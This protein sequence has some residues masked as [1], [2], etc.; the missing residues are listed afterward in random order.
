MV[1]V[2]TYQTFDEREKPTLHFYLYTSDYQYDFTNMV[3]SHNWDGDIN[4]ACESFSIGVHNKQ[5]N[6]ARRK[7]PFE[8]GLMIKV[9]LE[10]PAQKN[11]PKPT[12]LFRGIIAKRS[13]SGDGSE[14][15]KVNDYNWYF[16][17]NQV[18]IDFKNKTADQIISILCKKAGVGVS[19]MDKTG[20]VFPEL[21]F[22]R[23]TIW[24]II[25]A[26]LTETYLR[27]KKR[28]NI[29]SEYGKLS[30]R[31][32]TMSPNRM[33]IERGYNLLGIDR[34]ISIEDVRT[35]VIMTGGENNDNP[36]QIKVDAAAKKKYGTLT[37]TEHEQ[38]LT[39]P[40]AL[41]TLAQSLLDELKKPKDHLSV[42]ALADYHI[43]AGTLIEVYDEFT[44]ANDYYF[45]TAHSHSGQ[46][47]YGT[48]SLE[49]SKSYNPEFVRY[50]KPEEP[51]GEAV[52]ISFDSKLS[53][54]AYTSGFVATAYDPKLGGIN[55]SGDYS[56]TASGTK[57]AYSRTIA[58][59]PKVIPY[60]SIVH[61]VVPDMPEH[62][63]LYLAEDTG[64]AIDG[65]RIDMLIRGKKATANFGRRN[66]QVAILQKGTGK[67]DAKAK[68]A[69]WR[70]IESSWKKKLSAAASPKSSGGSADLGNVSDK[71]KK[72]VNL[73]RSYKGELTYLWSSMNVP[74][75][76]ADCS[77]FT[78]Y[79]LKNAAGYNLGRGTSSQ[80]TK[81]KKIAK[82]S[83]QPGDMVFFKNTYR[84]GVSHVGIVTTP[85]MCVSVHDGGCTEHSYTSGYW[86]GKFMQINRVFD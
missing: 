19:Y 62:N 36:G 49:L 72:V 75:G 61:I 48:M 81:G 60:G 44:G 64:G 38:D 10:Y 22:I 13:L 27:T 24:E 33:V 52:K 16:Q 74:G 70:S 79:I 17:R 37:L 80:V 84:T 4:L 59:D 8:E 83:A 20:Y 25:Q 56:M 55:G 85:G 12:E 11:A 30:L 76:T 63:G 45:V 46:S 53:D 68:A 86:G 51:K 82:S 43:S 39:G 3:T 18:T 1:L 21:E 5:D 29:R 26:V 14:E 34:D 71:R 66:I 28:Y 57:W 32:V 50:E 77:G 58:V 69:K 41:G 23:K 42:E 54:A 7:L 9:M 6:N 31:E 47:G 15:L 40:G 2:R 73:A 78:F 65:K 35:Q 67:A